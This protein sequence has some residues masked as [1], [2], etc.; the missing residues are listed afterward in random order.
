MPGLRRNGQC[1]KYKSAVHIMS[2]F[3]DE[4]KTVGIKNPRR[5][6]DTNDAEK[7][8][9]EWIFKRHSES[10]VRMPYFRIKIIF[11]LYLQLTDSAGS[12]LF[13]LLVVRYD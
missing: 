8:Y 11:Q 5:T 6:N 3:I 9:Q 7:E 13:F 10:V 2:A 1:L 12:L 4:I